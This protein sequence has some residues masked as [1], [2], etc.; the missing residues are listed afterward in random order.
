MNEEFVPARGLLQSHLTSSE[1]TPFKEA[2]DT[3]LLFNRS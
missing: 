3:I 2:G 1:Q